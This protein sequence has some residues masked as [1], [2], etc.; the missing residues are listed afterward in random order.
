[1]AVGN[2]I[3]PEERGDEGFTVESTNRAAAESAE[4]AEYHG[5]EN[6]R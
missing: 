3:C 2:M 5:M 6:G 1:M 4:S